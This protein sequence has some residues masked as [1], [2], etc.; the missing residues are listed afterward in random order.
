MIF[1]LD[2]ELIWLAKCFVSMEFLIE[3]SWVLFEVQQV[4]DVVKIDWLEGL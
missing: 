1:H 3:Q 2:H 4:L